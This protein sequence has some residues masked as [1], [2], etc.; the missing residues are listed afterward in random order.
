VLP[1]ATAGSD[2]SWFGFAL[3]LRKDAPID[4]H[5]LL[6]ELQ[7]KNIGTRLLFGGNLVRQPYMK[8]RNFRVSGTLDNADAIVDRTFW[9]GVYPALGAQEIDFMIETLDS[10]A[11]ATA[12]S[13][14]DGFH[15][16]RAH[17]WRPRA[18]VRR[19]SL[20]L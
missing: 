11:A 4:R 15:G 18:S 10:F 14:Y 8:G 2:P 19:A 12:G 16:A 6:L 20:V 1:E 5:G 7:A 13:P 3:T 9:I 17:P